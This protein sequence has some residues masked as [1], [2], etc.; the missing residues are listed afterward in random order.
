MVPVKPALRRLTAINMA[1]MTTVARR[2]NH[3]PSLAT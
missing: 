1:I 2:G 3:G